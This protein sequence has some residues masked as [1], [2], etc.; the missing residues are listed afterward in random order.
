MIVNDKG[1]QQIID[2]LLA[3]SR[4]RKAELLEFLNTATERELNELFFA[5][6]PEISL[7]GKIE[8]LTRTNEVVDMVRKIVG[9]E[10]CPV[11]SQK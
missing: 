1:T 8:A 11:E 9:M 10:I 5:I 6:Y 4:K 3:P 7:A 2:Q